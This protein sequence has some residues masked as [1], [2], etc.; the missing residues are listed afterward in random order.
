M[1]NTQP[2]GFLTRGQVQHRHW[3]CKGWHTD[4]SLLEGHR[5]NQRQEGRE[6]LCS[7]YQQDAFPGHPTNGQHGSPLD[8]VVI[9]T[10]KVPAHAKVCN[11]DGVAVP[12]QAVASCQIPVHK[13]QRCQVLHPRGDLGGHVQQ[14]GVAAVK[15]NITKKNQCSSPTLKTSLC[16]VC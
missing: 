14:V 1:S 11:L 6:A 9:P 8:P 4:V 5:E 10:V 13:V 16:V 3:W 2:C 7:A 12:H 15:G